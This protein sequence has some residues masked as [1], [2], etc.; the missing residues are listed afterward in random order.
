MTRL[1]DPTA[2]TSPTRRERL[3]RPPVL[4][5]LTVGILDISKPRGN[6]FLDRLDERLVQTGITVKR[7][8]KPTF[9]RPAPTPLRQQI[10]TEVDALVEGLAD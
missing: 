2:Q 10:A 6:V 8:I 5:G 9:A 7:Y 1:V 4:D 3:A